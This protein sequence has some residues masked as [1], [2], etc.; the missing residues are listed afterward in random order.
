MCDMIPHW[1]EAEM[2]K[3]GFD[4]N[5][6]TQMQDTER[7]R[8]QYLHG[9][10]EDSDDDDFDDFLPMRHLSRRMMDINVKPTPNL[11]KSRC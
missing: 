3:E 8:R 5:K 4:V 6:M 2:I 1:L 11:H 10:F 7:R 9:M